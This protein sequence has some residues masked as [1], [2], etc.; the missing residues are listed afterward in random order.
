MNKKIVIFLLV[1]FL[2]TVT[3]SAQGV[4]EPL[5]M[6]TAQSKITIYDKFSESVGLSFVPQSVNVGIDCGMPEMCGLNPCTC[7][8]ADSW[9][10]CSC[11]G[12]KTVTP[13]ITV[14]M[15]NA[16]IV[17]AVSKDGH[18]KIR[19]LK[20]GTTTVRITASLPHYTNAQQSIAVSVLPIPL[21][22]YFLASGCFATILVIGMLIAKKKIKKSQDSGM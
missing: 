20:P 7:G 15:S 18:I 21:G 1:C 13:D 5:E 17:S 10:S 11:N 19:A 12:L 16:G 6:H 22:W 3:A 8:S 9:G 4:A 14:Q 2:L